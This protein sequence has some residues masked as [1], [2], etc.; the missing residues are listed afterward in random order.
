MCADALGAEGKTTERFLHIL[1]VH[2]N[3]QG[4]G[5]A[6][7]LV[8]A[9]EKEVSLYHRQVDLDVLNCIRLPQKVE[10]LFSRQA[11]PKT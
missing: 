9:G 8:R 2:P 6:G 3:H 10:M 1:G 11:R 4:N 5:L 7:S